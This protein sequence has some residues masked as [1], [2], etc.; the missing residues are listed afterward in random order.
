MECSFVLSGKMKEQ[1]ICTYTFTLLNDMPLD[2]R[3]QITQACKYLVSQ[4]G[5][6]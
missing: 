2:L 3:E 4:E 6:K 1:S 5:K